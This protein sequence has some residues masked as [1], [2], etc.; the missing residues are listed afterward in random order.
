MLQ[1]LLNAGTIRFYS[2]RGIPII[3]GRK[4]RV[5]V[6]S[7]RYRKGSSLEEMMSQ[8]VWYLF[9]SNRQNL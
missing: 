9:R 6:S 3:D 1:S 4:L 8:T 7:R 2:K 5:V